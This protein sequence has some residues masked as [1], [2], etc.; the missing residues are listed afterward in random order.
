MEVLYEY[1]T[2]ASL[3]DPCQCRWPKSLQ[4]VVPSGG[5]ELWA[6][7][8]EDV[9]LY[10]DGREKKRVRVGERVRC[11]SLSHD[12]SVVWVGT[13]EGHLFSCDTSK[14]KLTRIPAEF[15]GEHIWQ[16]EEVAKAKLVVKT[17][18][19]L[20][21]VAMDGWDK[22]AVVEEGDISCFSVVGSAVVAFGQ[23]NRIK[24][25]PI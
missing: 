12:S 18:S 17:L 22:R 19:S 2:V 1:L 7:D 6:V 15:E 9:V 3:I 10:E 21:V 20:Y 24:L 8:E 5:D 11:L 4:M 16:V 25:A 23:N 14:N 13:D